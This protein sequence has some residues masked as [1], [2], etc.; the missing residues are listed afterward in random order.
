MFLC[1]YCFAGGNKNPLKRKAFK[2]VDQDKL[3]EALVKYCKHIGI[4]AA[5]DFR[6][7]YSMSVS[8]AVDIGGMAK[9]LPLIF[10]LLGS[11]ES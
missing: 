8:E 4:H 10:A 5:F 11:T 7:Y 1:S 3:E 2:E 9:L 6:S